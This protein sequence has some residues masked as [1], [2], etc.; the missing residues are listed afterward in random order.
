MAVLLERD[1]ATDTVRTARVVF[2]GAGP[3]PVRLPAAEDALVGTGDGEQAVAAA[4]RAALA[5]L[6]PTD[7]VHATAEYRRESAAHLLVRACTTAWE[8]S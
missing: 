1:A 5:R 8:R 6:T 3:V 4:A 7:D 2:C